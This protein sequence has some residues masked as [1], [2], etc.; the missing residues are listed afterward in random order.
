MK[1]KD[2]CGWVL[3]ALMLFG[4]YWIGVRTPPA[5]L[6]QAMG[7]IPSL[8]STNIIP[9]GNISVGADYIKVAK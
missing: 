9:T 7:G 5:L 4:V 6:T 8:S 2:W 1:I 3:A